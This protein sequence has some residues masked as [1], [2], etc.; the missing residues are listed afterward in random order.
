MMGNFYRRGEYRYY[1]RYQYGPYRACT[2]TSYYKPNGLYAIIGLVYC[3]RTRNYNYS[4]SGMLIGPFCGLG[5]ANWR[6]GTPACDPNW[7]LDRQNWTLA[8]LYRYDL[9]PWQ[10][11]TAIFTD[12]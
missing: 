11:C 5:L 10:Y 7:S 9:A 3:N 2:C 6:S 4:S 12:Q 1:Y 8:H